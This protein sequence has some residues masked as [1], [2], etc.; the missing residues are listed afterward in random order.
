M[1]FRPSRVFA[2]LGGAALLLLHTSCAIIE[3]GLPVAAVTVKANSTFAVQEVLESVF[4]DEGYH[5]SNRG[6]DS[7]TFE[8]EGSKVD[9]VLHGNWIDGEV[10][11]RAR[12]VIAARGEGFYRL[13]CLPSMVRDPNDVGFE[14]DHR[15]WQPFSVHYSHLL[16]EVRRQL[17]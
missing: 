13:R 10:A 5:V 11:Q 9:R 17:R 6:F 3:P 8:R 15:R 1:N 4:F 16:N 7:I 12:V 14:D 2:V